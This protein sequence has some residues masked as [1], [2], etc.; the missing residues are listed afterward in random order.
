MD[1]DQI[2]CITLTVHWLNNAFSDSV[3]SECDKQ[4][5][6]LC[7]VKQFVYDL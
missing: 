5:K 4:V 7:E 3:E 6:D 1:I 2:Y